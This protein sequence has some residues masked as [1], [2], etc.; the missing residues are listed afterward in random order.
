LPS[1]AQ[2]LG[3]EADVD[4]F[5]LENF[6]NSSRDILVFPC[7]K[8]RLHLDDGH[9]TAEPTIHL[10]ELKSDVASADDHQMLWQE[11]DVH[12]RAVR[13]IFNSFQTG[14]RRHRRAAPDIDENFFGREY[15]IANRNLTRG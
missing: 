14:K 1:D 10:R 2:A 3:V 9:R 4:A 11:V 15:F 7:D 12:H 13:Q 8:P 6:G 5:T